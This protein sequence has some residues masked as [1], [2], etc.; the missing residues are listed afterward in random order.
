MKME[1]LRAWTLSVCLA[2]A[3]AGVL[4]H[5]TGGRGK[6]PV[7]KLVL[8]LYILITALAPISRWRMDGLGA[9]WQRMQQALPAAGT[10]DARALALEAAAHRLEEELTEALHTEG[11][12][13]GVTV[14]LGCAEGLVEV[15]SVALYGAADLE[16]AGR[17]VQEFLGAQVP[18]ISLE[19][20][21][22]DG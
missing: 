17:T 4:G 12:T 18:V 10:I 14:R 16:C 2:C 20:E 3:A 11:E 8:S 19:E 21:V 6:E 1:T 22:Q 9:E 15:E 5:L 7:I 13:C